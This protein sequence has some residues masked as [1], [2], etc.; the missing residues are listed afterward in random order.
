MDSY[1]SIGVS[2]GASKN[3]EAC[4]SLYGWAASGTVSRMAGAAPV[5]TSVNM[6]ARRSA[7]TLIELLIVVAIIGILAAIAVPS[8]INARTRATVVR[9]IADLKALDI[10]LAQYGLDHNG[11][12]PPTGDAQQ[13]VY[14]PL[15]RLTTPF[16]Y[17]NALPQRDPFLPKSW[18]SDRPGGINEYWYD[19]FWIVTFSEVRTY[20]QEVPEDGR[21]RVGPLRYFLASVGPDR[22]LDPSQYSGW[23]HHWVPYSASNGVTSAGDVFVY[24]PGG[25]T[26]DN[27]VRH[28]ERQSQ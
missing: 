25:T 11:K 6:D 9:I 8:F 22:V 28:P 15:Y 16:P 12:Y 23:T 14:K 3:I 13:T 5:K 7:F 1:P 17:M 4:A 19:P 20:G 24:G 10:A 2:R 27:L 18:S 21:Y 26:S